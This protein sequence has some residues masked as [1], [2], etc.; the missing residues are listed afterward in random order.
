MEDY[1]GLDDFDDYYYPDNNSEIAKGSGTSAETF[2]SSATTK[3]SI[4][5]ISDVLTIPLE[6]K[7]KG[8]K[9]IID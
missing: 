5:V 6:S 1:Y 8:N 2:K 3:S 9:L 7:K 4:Q